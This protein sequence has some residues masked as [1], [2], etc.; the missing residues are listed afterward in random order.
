MVDSI[1]VE[2]SNNS[3]TFEKISMDHTIAVNCRLFNHA[4]VA[5]NLSITTDED[6]EKTSVLNAVDQN[7]Y[8]KLTFIIVS[9]PQKGNVILDQNTGFFV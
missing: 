3:Y 6:H 2:I 7:I 1:P 5:E 8:D 9:E 4:P